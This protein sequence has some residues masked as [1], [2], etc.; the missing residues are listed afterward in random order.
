MMRTWLLCLCLASANIHAAKLADSYGGHVVSPD[1]D[2]P[3]CD[4]IFDCPAANSS[5]PNTEDATHNHDPF[6]SAN[7]KVFKFNKALDTA[8]LKPVAKG[9]RKVVP[10][11][12]RTGVRNVFSNLGEV[13]TITNDVLQGK[14]GHAVEDLTRFVFNS[15]FGILGIFDVASHMGL[16]KRNEDFGQ[17]LGVWGV[18]PGPYLVLP[19]LGPSNGRD[20]VGTGV[21]FYAGNNA[22]T[23]HDGEKV[24]VLQ[25]ISNLNPDSH[26]IGTYALQVVDTRESLLDLEKTLDTLAIDEYAT[27]RD[28]Y[29]QNRRFKVYDGNPPEDPSLYP[30]E[31]VEDDEL[32]EGDLEAGL[33]DDEALLANAGNA[34]P[35]ASSSGAKSIEE[36][37]EEDEDLIQ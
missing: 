21:G 1:F 8:I 26:R 15:T 9:Y 31:F 20:L 34:A 29:L 6:E 5:E 30:E 25:P 13:L 7:R 16:E 22:T 19:F 33:E 10:R 23:Y 3:E 11:P 36:M 2:S 12:V 17:T 32:L 14:T 28:A 18:K 27:V 35:Q 4:L 37:L 24:Y